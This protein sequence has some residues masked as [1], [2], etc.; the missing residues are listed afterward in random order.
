MPAK[1]LAITFVGR[2]DKLYTRLAAGKSGMLALEAASR[3]YLRLSGGSGVGAERALAVLAHVSGSSV[4]SGDLVSD[5]W[6]P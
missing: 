6:S 2:I 5:G 4:F 1:R 3:E